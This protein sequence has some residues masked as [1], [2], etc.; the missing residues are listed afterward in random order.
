METPIALEPCAEEAPAV[1]LL[2]D[3]VLA[4]LLHASSPTSRTPAGATK[5]NVIRKPPLLNPVPSCATLGIEPCE[6]TGEI[7]PDVFRI[8]D[9]DRNA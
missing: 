9:P 4:E 5:R 1:A 8:L 3:D 7:A 6:R 2:D